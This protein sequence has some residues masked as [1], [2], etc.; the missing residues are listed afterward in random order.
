MDPICTAAATVDGP[1]PQASLVVQDS[2][3]LDQTLLAFSEDG[4]EVEASTVL[5]VL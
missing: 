1:R 4:H 3:A 5:L 2:D